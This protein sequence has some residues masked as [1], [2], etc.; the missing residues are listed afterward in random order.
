M[1]KFLTNF[2]DVFRA[3]IF[4]PNF[5]NIYFNEHSLIKFSTVTMDNDSSKIFYVRCMDGKF[6]KKWLIINLA[7]T[8]WRKLEFSPNEFKVRI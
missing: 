5:K 2:L 3:P 4:H 6:K 8:I 1:D 7:P